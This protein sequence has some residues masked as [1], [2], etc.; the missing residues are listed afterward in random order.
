MKLSE[1]R[2]EIDA[3]DNEIIDLLNKRFKVTDEV[4]RYKQKEN[5]NIL[6]YDREKEIFIIIENNSK[7]N[8]IDN[9]KD[10][11]TKIMQ[12]SKQRQSANK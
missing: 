1:Y 5:L 3:I 9:I 10:V 12:I 8:N 7:P 2:Q 4:G 11:Y 6:N